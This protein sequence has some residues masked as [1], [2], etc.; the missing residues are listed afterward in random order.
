MSQVIKKLLT[1][2]AV[3]LG[4]WVL[5]F[6]A[7]TAVFLLPEDNMEK[8]AVRSVDIFER[9]GT[10]P[11]MFDS[12]GVRMHPDNMFEIKTLLFN[13]R[14]TARDNFTDALMLENAI[15]DGNEEVIDK[16][17]NV[18]RWTDQDTNP[19]LSFKNCYSGQAIVK[20][21]R[22][23]YARYWHGYLVILK[24]LLL[25]L[26]Y[27]GIRILNYI[28][29]TAMLAYLCLLM[30]KK[31]GREMI[32]LYAVSLIFF[33][34]FTVPACMQFATVS[35]ITLTALI[36][37]FKKY[38]SISAKNSFGAMFLLLGIV[39][40]Y[41]DY[42]TFPILTFGLPLI[43]VIMLS[44]DSHHFSKLKGF[45]QV[46]LWGMVWSM[47]YV[48]MWAGKW[49]LAS[50]LTDSN[51]IKEALGKIAER[52]NALAGVDMIKVS[53]LR[54][55]ASN[56]CNYVN[57]VYILIIAIILLWV[58]SVSI[59]NRDNFRSTLKNNWILLVIGFIPVVWYA[60]FRNHS[61][62]HSSFTFRSLQITALAWL[63][64]VDRCKD[65]IEKTRDGC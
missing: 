1:Y 64:F 48:G 65:T 40:A 2:I 21:Q 17:L 29:M 18:Y 31:F 8:N 16:A 33:W 59:K 19:V 55:I 20:E 63:V 42:L 41:F 56:L 15:Y 38:D 3:I 50:L 52:T 26:T 28:V 53:A 23:S 49:I 34:P 4:S 12:V 30:L 5:G 7:L 11:T 14:I 57:I 54:S 39:T 45:I 25:F 37:L 24:P 27:G 47:G 44:D 10:Y 60:T 62:E 36:V 13:N 9:E 46:A 22:D 43:F 58:L 61:Y 51:V 6:I 32:G 35:Y